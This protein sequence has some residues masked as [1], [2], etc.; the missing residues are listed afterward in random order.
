MNV[1]GFDGHLSVVV[2]VRDE[3]NNVAALLSEIHEAL[4]K[5]SNFEVIYVDDGS[6]DATFQRAAELRVKFPRLRIIRHQ[7]SCGQSAAISTG[8]RHARHPWVVT[9]DG[10]GQNDP[11]DIPALLALV[12][13]PWKS[14]HLIIGRRRE[15]HDP[16]LRRLSSR[17]ANGVRAWLLGDR[18]PDTGCGLKL[19]SRE[20]F[21][22]L[23]NFDHMHRFLPALVL[24]SGGQVLSV[25]VSHRP[26]RSGRSNYGINN[27]L[28]AGIV[29]LLG[30]LWLQRR[31]RNPVVI[32]ENHV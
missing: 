26:R 8:I 11:A 16:R 10:D 1:A 7:E 24:R 23:P 28:W 17:V 2:P 13:G 5:L 21:L 6:T 30:V 31:A 14:L 29:D 20:A 27:R 18:A 25:D 9:L 32:E 12:N 15:R 19:V 4:A 3:Q 22:A